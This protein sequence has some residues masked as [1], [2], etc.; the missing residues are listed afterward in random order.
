[1]V[2][3][4]HQIIYSLK[5]IFHFVS[6]FHLVAIILRTHSCKCDWTNKQQSKSRSNFHWQQQQEISL[7]YLATCLLPAGLNPQVGHQK[8][9]RVMLSS[10]LERRHNTHA[11]DEWTKRDHIDTQSC[12]SRDV[13]LLLTLS[14]TAHSLALPTPQ[15]NFGFIDIDD[16][17]WLLSEIWWLEIMLQIFIVSNDFYVNANCTEECFDGPLWRKLWRAQNGTYCS[18]CVGSGIYNERF[19]VDLWRISVPIK[20]NSCQVSGLRPDSSYGLKYF[21]WYLCSRLFRF[22]VTVFR[23]QTFSELMCLITVTGEWRFS[24][25]NRGANNDEQSANNLFRFRLGKLTPS[26]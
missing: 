6:I 19:F 26:Q 17:D 8:S 20:K 3:H 12:L 18:T 13:L 22:F 9:A 7:C 11:L 25:E 10:H 16:F 5:G 24:L 23:H 21:K 1:M 2:I 14:F 15:V 4:Q